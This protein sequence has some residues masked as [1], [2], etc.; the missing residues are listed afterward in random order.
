MCELNDISYRGSQLAF[1]TKIRNRWL[2]HVAFDYK[3]KSVMYHY[4]IS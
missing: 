3:K 4:I 1:L 2:Q